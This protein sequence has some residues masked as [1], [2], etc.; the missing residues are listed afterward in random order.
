MCVHVIRAQSL[1]PELMLSGSAGRVGHGR[2]V[3]AATCVMAACA[4]RA[5]IVAPERATWPVTVCARTVSAGAKW[6]MLQ[7]PVRAAA[8]PVR[9]SECSYTLH[10]HMRPMRAGPN[11]HPER[12]VAVRGHGDLL[13]AS[14]VDS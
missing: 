3:C 10:I 13:N 7:V 11:P 6:T 5:S 8:G 12:Y 14:I 9:A 2:A 1:R 4:I